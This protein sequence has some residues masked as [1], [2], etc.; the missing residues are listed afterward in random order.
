MLAATK[1]HLAGEVKWGRACVL[2]SIVILRRW[3]F[4]DAREQKKYPR[5]RVYFAHSHRR[6]RPLAHR[7]IRVYDRRYRCRRDGVVAARWHIRAG[8]AGQC[9]PRGLSGGRGVISRGRM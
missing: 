6:F 2:Q 1:N 9:P 8:R 3:Y 7:R 4:L 5:R